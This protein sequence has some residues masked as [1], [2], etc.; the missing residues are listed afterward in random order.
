MKWR[1]RSVDSGPAGLLHVPLGRV[2]AMKP[3]VRTRAL[4]VAAAVLVGAVPA[5][6]PENSLRISFGPIPMAVGEEDDPN[7]QAEM[8]FLM[9]RDPRTNAIPP[10]IRAREAQF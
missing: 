4:L 9:L 1:G 2:S 7:A 10:G 5:P 3:A 8:E 6:V